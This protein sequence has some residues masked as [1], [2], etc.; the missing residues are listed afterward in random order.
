MILPLLAAC[1]PSKTY[2]GVLVGNPGEVSLQTA[3][4]DGVELYDGTAAVAEFVMRDCYGED[5]VIASR[6]TMDLL[7]GSTLM[8]P[9]GLWCS[10]T[11]ELS[12]S[13]TWGGDISGTDLKLTLDPAELFVWAPEGFTTSDEMM[14]LQLGSE[15]W[16]SD[17]VASGE[18]APVIDDA[19]PLYCL[20][21]TSDAAD[22]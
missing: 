5:F 22:E 2:Q 14:V 13:L 21:Y 3:E 4:T 15:E 16:L 11:I 20:L 8:V 7:G 17:V 6:L 10:A 19:H 9:G 12:E 18:E 1:D